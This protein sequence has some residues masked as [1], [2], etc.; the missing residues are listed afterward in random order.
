MLAWNKTSCLEIIVRIFGRADRRNCFE[1]ENL[2]PRYL[3]VR[4]FQFDSNPRCG[5]CSFGLLGYSDDTV[6]APSADAGMR[7][8]GSSRFDLAVVDIFLL[9]VRL[10]K[11]LPGER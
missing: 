2:C 8:F 3:M 7:A 9:E 5:G 11:G 10:I 4:S 1:K 6:I